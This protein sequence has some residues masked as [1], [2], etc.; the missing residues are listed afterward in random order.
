MP[1][2]QKNSSVL[3]ADVAAF[4]TF[5]F[6]KGRILLTLAVF[7]PKWALDFVCTVILTTGGSDSCNSYS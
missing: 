3:T 5:N 1:N 6:H 4:S 2:K 7:S